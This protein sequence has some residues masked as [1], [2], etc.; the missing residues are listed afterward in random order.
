MITYAVVTKKVEANMV[1]IEIPRH[2]KWKM[3]I[4]NA[5]ISRKAPA[6]KRN[7]VPIMQQNL[8]PP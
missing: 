2:N 7:Y 3:I 4:K 5:S 6:K 1:G 8:K